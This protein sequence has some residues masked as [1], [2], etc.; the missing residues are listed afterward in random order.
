MPSIVSFMHFYQPADPQSCYY[1]VKISEIEAEEYPI[2]EGIFTVEHVVFRCSWHSQFECSK[3]GKFHHFSWLFWCPTEER[4]IC[5]SCRKP[6]MK[7]IKFWD[8]TYAYEFFCEK[9]N[10][11][12]Y[13]LFYSEF[14]GTHPWQ[15]EHY[16]LNSIVTIPENWMPLWKPYNP[17]MGENIAIEDALSL[18]NNVEEIRRR[19]GDLE[20]HSSLTP[21]NEVDHQDIQ[22]KWEEDS[23][24]WI[25][26][27]EKS[28]ELDEGDISRQLII[29]P[30]FWK[31]LD[32]VQG[33]KVLDAGCGNGYFARKLA[34]KGAKVYGVDFSDNFI[35]YCKV[36][37]AK[38]QL[39]AKFLQTSLTDLSFFENEFFDLIISNVVLV[40]VQ[41]YQKAFFEL[42][43][44]LKQDGRF[45]WSN[46]HPAFGRLGSYLLRLPLDTSRNEERRYNL[47]DRYFDSGGTLVSWENFQPLW[48]FHRTFSEY[49]HALKEAGFTIREIIEPKPDLGLIKE[50]PRALAFNADRFPYFIIFDCIKID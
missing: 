21:Q 4:L 38:E 32:N 20:F 37:E 6:S 44:I 50:N 27:Y 12:H 9:C 47:V 25:E 43:R 15:S 39:G 16:K 42:N 36:R 28:G 8:K 23:V 33:L 48:Q 5:G 46:L 29:D 14:R 7:P 1:C 45:I 11:V 10:E 41:D 34:K 17:R 18:S 35:E 30:A 13:D 2:R 24:N 3:C 49:S 40:D 26:N 31:I 19:L 22:K